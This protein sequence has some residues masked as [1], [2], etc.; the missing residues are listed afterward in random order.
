M[1]IKKYAF[2]A[3]LFFCTTA[4]CERVEAKELIIHMGYEMIQIID[5][6]DDSITTIP[7]KGAS[8]D[9]V[10]SAD[11][12]SLF[13]TGSRTVI[14]KLD[15]VKKEIVNSITVEEKGWER[16]IYGIAVS[17]DGKTG[18]VNVFSRRTEK[19]EAVINHPEVLQIDLA[20]GK[21]LRSLEVPYGVVSLALVENDTKLYAMGQD[22][23]TIDVTQKQMK[24]V[25]T[26][27]LFDLGINLF[28]LWH[29]TA[30]NDG[31][32]LS[33][34]Y[35]AEGMGLLS[36]DTKSGTVTRTMLEGE[37]PFAYNAVYSPDKTK[38]YAVMDEVAVIDLK[39]KTYA[40]IV[41]IPEGTCYGVMPTSDGKKVYAG[42]GGSTITVFDAETMEPIKIL[43]M[44]SDGM[45]LRRVT[46]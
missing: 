28:A 7:M 24:I 18:Y 15:L 25:N 14:H 35:S 40:K 29:Y 10:F 23:S 8:R 44:D 9:S 22:I 19:G 27:G 39:T 21:I 11:R 17:K 45:G 36:I 31:V 4:I 32:W 43:Q 2:L 26:D 3:A 20:N 30:E 34:Y 1:N 6:D 16:F 37:P 12:K 41:P 13:I 33:P 5:A 38:A 46:L 42:G